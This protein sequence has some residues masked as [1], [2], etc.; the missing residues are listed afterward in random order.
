MGAGRRFGP[1]PLAGRQAKEGALADKST[2]LVLEALSR[3]VA[4]P[5]GVPLVGTR[6]APGLFTATGRHLAQRCKDEG[7]LRTVRSETKGKSVLEVCAITE[8]GLSHLL[9]QVS[10]RQVLEDLV[11]TLQARH[12]Q[13]AELVTAARQ[14]QTS[15]DSLRA[16]VEKVLLQL[17]Q[18]RNGIATPAASSPGPSTNGSEIW[19]VEVLACLSQWH[20][21]GTSNDCPLPELYRRARNVAPGLTIGHFHDGIRRLH[22]QDHVYLHP[23]TGPLYEIPEPPYA[24]LIGHEIAYYASIR[25][26]EN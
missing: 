4:D 14:W 5:G 21:T 18:T 20:A 1:N 22:E 8:K 12:V 10:P 24:L 6:K 23:W 19:T 16:T 26:K 13:V 17:Q 9:S 25:T 11:R 3:A 2:Q 15:L 7:L